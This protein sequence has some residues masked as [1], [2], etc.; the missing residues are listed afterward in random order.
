MRENLSTAMMQELTREVRQFETAFLAGADL[1]GRSAGRA[2]SLRTRN[3]TSLVIRC[4]ALRPCCTPRCRPW[5][6]EL[7]E[8]YRDALN[9]PVPTSI[10]HRRCRWQA[11]VCP[12]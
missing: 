4:W 7:V 3:G 9:L 8:A 5:T 2:S 6:G 1:P 11:L 12:T 10:Q